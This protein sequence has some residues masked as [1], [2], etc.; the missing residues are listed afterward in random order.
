M[1]V[2]ALDAALDD[3]A[4]LDV[5]RSGDEDLRTGLLALLVAQHRVAAQVTRLVG[6]FE[7]RG[8]AGDDAQRSTKAWLQA[9][10]RLSEQQA[11]SLVRA[12]HVCA[13]LPSLAGA[14]ADGEINAEHVDTLGLL[15][16]RE[17][18]EVLRSAAPILV[19]LAQH[20]DPHDLRR[21]CEHLRLT[22]HNG[23]YRL[24][25]CDESVPRSDALA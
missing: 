12:A 24:A 2:D 5:A 13:A 25:R 15:G 17:P 14:F 7:R 20:N 1:L 22:I 3:L 23:R 11:R 19:P 16:E 4:E 8:L 6:E 21:A 18:L 10:G 9:H